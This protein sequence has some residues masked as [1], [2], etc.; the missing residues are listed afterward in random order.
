MKSRQFN[1]VTVSMIH[2]LCPCQANII[3]LGLSQW[4]FNWPLCLLTPPTFLSRGIFKEK[5]FRITNLIMSVSCLNLIMTSQPLQGWNSNS[6]STRPLTGWPLLTCLA[7]CPFLPSHSPS[8]PVRVPTSE[9]LHSLLTQ[10]LCQALFKAWQWVRAVS[11]RFY[12]CR[13]LYVLFCLE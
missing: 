1:P 3:S 2:L 13:F 5:S 7:H 8:N 11:C 9:L 12:T 10:Q 4:D 6:Q